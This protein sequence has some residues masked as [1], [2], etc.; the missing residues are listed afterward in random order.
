MREPVAWK[1]LGRRVY[2]D[3]LAQQT[4]A[5]ETRRAGG[6][7]VC[8]ALEHPPTVTLGKRA[9][10]ADLRVSEDLLAAR[11]IACARVERGGF[12]TYHGPGQLV[13]YPIV[14][15]APR[16]FGVGTFVAALEAIMIDLAAVFGVAA[17]RDPRGR[18]VWTE[19]GKLGAVGIRVRDG[20]ST[21][22]LA[23][24]VDVDLQAFDVIAPCGMPG[25]AVTSLRR[26]GTAAALPQVATAAQ[27]IACRHLAAAPDAERWRAAV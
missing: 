3:A 16:G 25:V 1:W 9:G 7:D 20:I 10:A 27:A 22:G 13:L 15:L 5:W 2:D 23:L 18:G 19:R 8:L 6:S 12:A 24:N 4:A 26:E 21:H 14:A 17:R 11:G